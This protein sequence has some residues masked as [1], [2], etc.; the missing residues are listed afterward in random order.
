MKALI[1]ILLSGILVGC[2]STHESTIRTES[3]DSVYTERISEI[4]KVKTNVSTIVRDT[5][6]KIPIPR[7][8]AEFTGADSSCLETD[9]A[10]S[11]SWIDK[12]GNLKHMIRSKDSAEV[13][14][15]GGHTEIQTNTDS[16]RTEITDRNQT[17]NE[18]I[19]S[20][21]VRTKH[22]FMD[23]LFYPL[24]IISCL[25]AGIYITLKCFVGWKRL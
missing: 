14:V 25:F 1:L 13:R 7:Q 21:Q 2:R 16:I 3:R 15:P 11:M 23:W 9:F 4:E 19:N 18:A 17:V 20:D 12:W 8:T 6:L 10:I 24:G 5:V 22:L